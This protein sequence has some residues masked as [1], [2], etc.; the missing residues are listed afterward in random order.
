MIQ[1]QADYTSVDSGMDHEDTWAFSVLSAE[2][3]GEFNFIGRD[4]SIIMSKHA[5]QTQEVSATVQEMKRG[6]EGWRE[7]GH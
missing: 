6:R 4:C 5:P 1:T 3:Q 7:R 2:L